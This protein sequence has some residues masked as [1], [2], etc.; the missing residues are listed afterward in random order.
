[1]GSLIFGYMRVP[2]AMADE[3][4]ERRHGEMAA[5]AEAEGLVLGG[6]FHELVPGAQSAFGDLVEALVRQGSRHV[7]VPSIRELALTSPLQDVMVL[8]LQDM[9]GAETHVL[10]EL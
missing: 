3:E 9:A 4:V 8:H 7:V 1:M 2:H 6:V 5:Y 10:D